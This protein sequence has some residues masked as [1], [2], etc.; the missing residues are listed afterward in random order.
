MPRSKNPLQIFRWVGVRPLLSPKEDSFLSLHCTMVLETQ[1][2]RVAFTHTSRASVVREHKR[3]QRQAGRQAGRQD[4]FNQI[5]VKMKNNS[6]NTA[7]KGRIPP[8]MTVNGACMYHG[9]SGM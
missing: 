2:P 4:L 5:E 6:M 8:I 3:H 7:P 9:C 1:W